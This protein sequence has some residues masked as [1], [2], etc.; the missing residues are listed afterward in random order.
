MMQPTVL[1]GI[2]IPL[3]VLAGVIYLVVRWLRARSGIER[4]G[5]G[6]GTVRQ[7]YSYVVALVALIVGVNGLVQIER[8]A[9]D[10]LF[11]GQV[12]V[13]SRSGLAIGISLTVVGFAVWY[14]HWRF[15]QNSLSQAPGER[16]ALVRKLYVYA[17]LAIAGGFLLAAS[18]D[19]LG[20]LLG[21]GEFSEFSAL[22]WSFLT[23]WAAVWV[24]HWQ[25]EAREGQ[26]TAAALS[27]RRLYLYGASVVTLVMAASGSGSVIERILRNGYDV[28]FAAAA[29][30]S[31]RAALWSQEMTSSLALV[32][33]GG[34]GWYFHYLRFGAG[35]AESALK[36]LYLFASALLG[37]FALV[38]GS[39]AV[40]LFGILVWLIG[41]PAASASAH[42]SFL[43]GA[44]AALSVG[45]AIW[46]YHRAKLRQEAPDSPLG[47]VST[48]RI[49]S[50]LAAAFGLLALA[51][52]AGAAA[53]NLTAI[54]FEEGEVLV[55]ANYWRN[56]IASSITLVAVGLV[57]WGFYWSLAQGRAL[58]TGADERLALSRRLFV[59]AALGSAALA[60]IGSLS[61]LLFV[62]LRDLLEAELELAVLYE[63]RYA[64]GTIAIALP[65]V[66]Y[67]WFIHRQDR[68]F[69]PPP[70][71]D[72][73]VPKAVTA[74]IAPGGEPI[75]KAL[76]QVL[77]YKVAG[78]RWVDSQGPAQF[79]GEDDLEEIAA[80]ITTAEGS[81]VLVALDAAGFQVMSYDA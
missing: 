81:S 15:I 9:L 57:T 38:L 4:E 11:G 39:V 66:A 42:F 75:V 60:L 55:G 10:A 14:A 50:Y 59:F 30:D 61:Y 17:A 65:V 74:L 80:R 12:L 6:V 26:P 68:E 45:I 36:Q 13:P 52:G 7:V 23:I 16:R 27:L 78:Q 77:G 53:S 49:Y 76:E 40:I 43:P 32:I 5:S 34:I 18:T 56:Q 20:W 58:A 46:A 79:P 22:S 63:S 44:I 33:V 51:I 47:P 19:I 71:V 21:F 41:A 31:S 25:L 64:V 54:L 8:F 29:L 24:Y 28:A 35:Q 62:V 73:P 72:Q 37:G 2:L 1:F 69:E 70:Q 67:Y 3:G 48:E